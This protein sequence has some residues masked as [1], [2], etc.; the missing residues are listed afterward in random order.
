M[1]FMRVYYALKATDWRN[2]FRKNGVGTIEW[3]DGK[4]IEQPNS[5]ESAF[6][7]RGEISGGA[8]GLNVKGMFCAYTSLSSFVPQPKTEAQHSA[9]KHFESFASPD[10]RCRV[11]LHWKCEIHKT[12]RG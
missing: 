11:G 3:S 4:W 12:W 7:I 6:I 8:R 9:R 1:I 5:L 2:Y 10:C